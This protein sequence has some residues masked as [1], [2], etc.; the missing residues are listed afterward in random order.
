MYM[1]AQVCAY[2]FLSPT[3]TPGVLIQKCLYTQ[4]N[5]YEYTR[6]DAR[7][8]NVYTCVFLPV[9]SCCLSEGN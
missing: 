7:N 3:C 6:K 4:R 5:T 1:F 8:L 9:A 2:M